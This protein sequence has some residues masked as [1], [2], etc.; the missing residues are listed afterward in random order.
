MYS[1]PIMNVEKV[2]GMQNAY[3]SKAIFRATMSLQR[4]FHTSRVLNFDDRETHSYKRQK[5]KFPAICD[6]WDMWVDIFSK[7][8]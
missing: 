3:K 6:L 8:F 1:S 7:T 5:V 2:C 4:F